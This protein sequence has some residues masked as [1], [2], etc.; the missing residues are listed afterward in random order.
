MPWV[1]AQP[2][3]IVNQSL[4]AL[5]AGTVIGAMTDGTPIS[6]AARRSYGPM[7]RQLLRAAHWAFARKSSPLQLLGDSSGQSFAPNGTPLSVNVEQPWLYAYAWPIDGVMARW[8]PWAPPG[9]VVIPPNPPIPLTTAGP[10]QAWYPPQPARFLVSTSEQFPVIIGE[11]DWDN[12]PDLQGTEG[13][14]LTAR[15]VILTN[16]PQATFVY[17]KL[18]L[19][20][21]QWDPLFRQAVV[22]AMA[23]RLAMVALKDRKVAM[24]ERSVQIALAKQALQAARVASANDSG[25]PQTTDHTPNWIAARSGGGWWGNGNWGNGGAGYTW[26]GWSGYAFSDGGVF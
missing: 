15:Q 23:E 13:V 7:V 10:L 16:V 17:T 14:G 26:V 6:E 8:L 9:A 25:F 5:G 3:D 21:E 22:A 19:E 2:S 20:I 11:V 12:L 4:D 24:T 1:P 18:I